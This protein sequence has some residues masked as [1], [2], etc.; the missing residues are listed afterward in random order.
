L[1]NNRKRLW[2][3]E[4]AAYLRVSRSTLSKWRMNNNG[5]PHHRCGPRLVYYYQDEIDQWL[6]GCDRSCAR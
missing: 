2:A 6:A 3:V 4:A 1:S 5:P